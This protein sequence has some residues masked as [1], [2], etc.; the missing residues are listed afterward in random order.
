MVVQI[1]KD[2]ANQGQAAHAGDKF[3]AR[4]KPEP[5]PP[6]F[7]FDRGI[8]IRGDDSPADGVVAKTMRGALMPVPHVNSNNP[9]FRRLHKIKL[10][11]RAVHPARLFLHRKYCCLYR[12]SCLW[13]NPPPLSHM[14]FLFAA[15]LGTAFHTAAYAQE[16]HGVRTIA[17][18]VNLLVREIPRPTRAA[19]DWAA[20][21]ANPLLSAP[22]S[23]PFE[24][25]TTQPALRDLVFENVFVPGTITDS[26][27]DTASVQ[28]IWEPA[29]EWLRRSN[30]IAAAGLIDAGYFVAKEKWGTKRP[31]Q[32]IV[33]LYTADQPGQPAYVQIDFTPGF[34]VGE[35]IS[36][37]NGDGVPEVFAQ[38]KPETVAPVAELLHDYNSEPLSPAELTRHVNE[39]AGALYDK[40]YVFARE[41]A[42]FNAGELD[43]PTRDLLG[44]L[45]V[46]TPAGIIERPEALDDGTPTPGR[47]LMLLYVSGKTQTMR[48]A[49]RAQVIFASDP[50]GSDALQT[51]RASLH[52]LLNAD[53]AKPRVVP[54]REPGVL[55]LRRALEYLAA[56]DLQNQQ[57]DPVPVLVDFSEQLQSRGI[58]FIFVPIPVKAVIYPDWVAAVPPEVIVNT[59]GQ[60]AFER[61]RAAGVKVLDPA[62]MLREARKRNPGELLYMKTDTHWTPHGAFLVAEWV[63][64]ELRKLGVQIG[65]AVYRSTPQEIVFTGNLA[66]MLDE[67]ER[68]K[69]PLEKFK[70]YQVLGVDGAPL[71]DSVPEAPILVLGDSYT[72]IFQREQCGA[73][74]F[75]AHLA[76]RLSQPVDLIAAQGGGPQTRLDLAR[77]GAGYLASKK[78]VILA[79]S[80]RDLFNYFGGWKK[81]ALP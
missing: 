4:A 3:I 5:L 50:G 53:D 21:F 66:R 12:W 2:A 68:Q 69:Y 28:L 41:P 70:A 23:K 8:V 35:G 47:F 43:P 77:R 78:Y 74:G 7:W 27:P 15:L 61:L 71:A 25:Q 20:Y 32:R 62:P 31:T 65:A 40:H 57:T 72:T 29:L 80:E 44:S 9:G 18:H 30:E 39:I 48:R 58:S 56:D 76:A 42:S 16:A 46:Q 64:E 26:L 22:K 75:A 10:C 73:A 24:H 36:D 17:S 45:A 51:F 14:K 55:F 11:E 34:A 79:M 60:A 54:G 52:A 13:R 63:A 67:S 33:A 37:S 59:A 38:L 81:V 19:L 6:L 49:S 1:P